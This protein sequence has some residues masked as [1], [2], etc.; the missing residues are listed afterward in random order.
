MLAPLLLPACLQFATATPAAQAASLA[1]PAATL[2]SVAALSAQTPGAAARVVV[3]NPAGTS[4]A[5][6]EIHPDAFEM[7]F[8]T[9]DGIWIGD[10]NPYTGLFANGDGLDRFVDEATP[11]LQARNGPEYGQD[12]DGFSIFYN[13]G[14]QGAPVEIWRATPKGVGFLT[15]LLTLPNAHRFNQLPSQWPGGDQTHVLYART[16]LNSEGFGTISRLAEDSGDLDVPAMTR[17][18][19]TRRPTAR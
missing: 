15:S 16:E 7:V 8:Q 19:A 5:D 13:R 14:G 17:R 11:V 4:Y 10:I 1:R 12:Q 3:M 2:P 18:S 6:P 9:P